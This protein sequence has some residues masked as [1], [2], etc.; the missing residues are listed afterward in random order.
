MKV[1]EVV[2]E[3]WMSQLVMEVMLYRRGPYRRELM[4]EVMVKGQGGGTGTREN[5]TGG[6]AGNMCICI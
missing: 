4:M 3:G 5:P 1:V 2:R 6:G